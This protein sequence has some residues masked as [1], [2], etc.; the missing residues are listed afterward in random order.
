MMRNSM[1][2]IYFEGIWKKNGCKT[3]CKKIIQKKIFTKTF[4]VFVFFFCS[5]FL[6]FENAIFWG[7]M[8][9][10]LFLILDCSMCSFYWLM[11]I[12]PPSPP[13]SYAPN[14]TDANVTLFSFSLVYH[15]YYSTILSL[16]FMNWSMLFWLSVELFCEE[17]FFSFLFFSNNGIL[18][19]LGF[20]FQIK[21][22]EG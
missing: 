13:I 8:F 18:P 4:Q 10:F 14:N 9:G 21:K 1:L 2:E 22:I 16:E 3:H 15:Y 17:N 12:L 19:R 6:F 7:C 5:W 20:F 11:V